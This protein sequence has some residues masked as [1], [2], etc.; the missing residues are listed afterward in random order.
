MGQKNIILGVILAGF[1]LPW[2]A[3]SASVILSDDEF[4]DDNWVHGELADDSDSGTLTV[5]RVLTGGNPGSHQRGVH[6]WGAGSSQENPSFVSY[7]HWY[8]GGSYDPSVSGEIVALGFTY[9]F[10]VF[11]AT[12]PSTGG[13][14][15]GFLLTQGGINRFFAQPTITTDNSAWVTQSASGLTSADFSG[16]DFS[17]SGGPIEFGYYTTNSTAQADGRT[18]TWGVDNWQVV[19]DNRSADVPEPATWPLLTMGLLGAI[20]ARLHR[21][22]IAMVQ[23]T[24]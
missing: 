11:A 5:N 8:R 14:G 2:Q 6:A 15:N 7:G 22:R 4:V 20:G 12:N 18:T 9:D 24:L 13:V 23:A 17:S 19:I 21:R 16:V 1:A 3:T 10:F